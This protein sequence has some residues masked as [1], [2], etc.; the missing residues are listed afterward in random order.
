MDGLLTF[1]FKQIGA[2]GGSYA[3]LRG[4]RV[5]I[6]MAGVCGPG[7]IRLYAGQADEKDASRFAI[8]FEAR[9]V[10]GWIDGQFVGGGGKLTLRMENP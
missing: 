9:G 3:W 6:D 4:D 10:R 8:P 5:S 1:Q 7:E 2:S